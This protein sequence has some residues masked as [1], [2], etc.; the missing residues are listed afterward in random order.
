MQKTDRAE[1]MLR[2]CYPEA[3]FGGFSSVDGTIAFYIRINAMLSPTSRVL[4]IGC[5]RGK[6]ADDKEKSLFKHNLRD[7][8]KKCSYV[9]GIDVSDAGYD[10]PFLN[11]FRRIDNISRWPVEDSSID[12]AICDYVLEHIENPD[13]FFG[14]CAR[15]IKPGGVIC[16]R[17]PNANSYIAWM[18]RLIPNRHHAHVV[19]FATTRGQECDVFPTLYYCNT[20]RKILRTMKQAGFDSC[21]FTWE[22]EPLYLLFS[23]LAYRIGAFIHKHLLPGPLQS[24]IM[25]FGRRKNTSE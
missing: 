3:D 12:V 19:Q 6:A 7:I 14:E 25:A 4:D 9:L 2:K 8:K 21:A 22:A 24:T 5:G 11:E 1:V 18:S 23:P 15:I 13:S 17:T 16:I 10:N 20:R